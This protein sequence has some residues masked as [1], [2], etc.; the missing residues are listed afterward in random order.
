MAANCVVVRIAGKMST[1]RHGSGEH[2]GVG[3]GVGVG[4]AGGG[5][6]EASLDPPPPQAASRHAAALK[7][8]S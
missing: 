4:V 8:R 6:A 5:G 3:V 1:L 7:A 2:A